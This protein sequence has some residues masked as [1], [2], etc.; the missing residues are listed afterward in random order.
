MSDTLV[1][2]VAESGLITLRPEEWIPKDEIMEF[3]LKPFLFQGL[4]LREQDFRD[5]IKKHAWDSYKAK[6]VCV[7]CSA[8]AIIPSWAF[9]LVTA[10]LAPVAKSVFYGTQAQWTSGQMLMIIDQI[11][12]ETYR[13]QRVIIKGCSNGVVIGP[14]VFVA[15]SAKL[16]PV[17]QS[18]M[19]GEPCSTVPVYKRPKGA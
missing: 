14:E 18:L 8:D 1:N 10:M 19:F 13:D 16:V 17:V 12:A 3:D 11:N 2:R 5:Q 4:M 15:L 6:V 7:H 9:M